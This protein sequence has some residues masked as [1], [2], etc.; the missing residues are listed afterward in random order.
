MMLF[1]V[2]Y[3]SEHHDWSKNQ[4]INITC[5][6]KNMQHFKNW[7]KWTDNPSQLQITLTEMLFLS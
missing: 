7:D 5:M 1:T 3:L 6:Q 4:S 2:I